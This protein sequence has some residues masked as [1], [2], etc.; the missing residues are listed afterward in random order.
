MR[1]RGFIGR[2]RLRS[3]EGVW[4]VPS[5]GVHTLGVFVPLDLIYLDEQ[6]VVLDLRESFP[7]FRIGPY[8]RRAASVLELPQY[9]IY[10]SQTQVGD[11]LLIC[12]AAEMK[13]R[14]RQ[15]RLEKDKVELAGAVAWRPDGTGGRG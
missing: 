14:L 7:R 8:R 9:T 3:D 12:P 4:V 11:R 6:Y 5:N 15:I 13:Q 2:G 10:A 1:L